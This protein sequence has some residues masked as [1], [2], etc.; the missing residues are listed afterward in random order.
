[1][2][3]PCQFH[4]SDFYLSG[5]LNYFYIL[6]M[7]VPET[8]CSVSV[9]GVAVVPPGRGAARRHQ[10]SGR[11]GWVFLC[12]DP[13]APS[14]QSLGLAWPPAPLSCGEPANPCFA[15]CRVF[16]M[17]SDKL[18]VCC[19]GRHKDV[20]PG[21]F[22]QFLAAPSAIAAGRQQWGWGVCWADLDPSSVICHLSLSA[23]HL[24]EMNVFWCVLVL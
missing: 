7:N 3:W 17:C 18:H 9:M 11:P 14:G 12:Q 10:L 13:G 21:G 16:V 1:M 22:A 24:M 2:S 23:E 19:W 6:E 15:L 8:E 4:G 20:K 5:N